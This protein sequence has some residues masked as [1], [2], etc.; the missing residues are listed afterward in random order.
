MKEYKVKRT[1]LSCL[2]SASSEYVSGEELSEILGFSRANTWKYIKK[3]INDGYQIEAVSKKGYKLISCPDKLYGYD[4]S[5]SLSSKLMGKNNIYYYET[6]TSTNDK[7]YQLAELGAEEGDIIVS[8]EQTG[9]KGRLGRKWISPPGVGLYFSVILR[10]ALP[11]TRLPALT[12]VSSYAVVKVLRE[13]YRL[14]AGIKWPND[15]YAQGKKIGGILTEIKAQQDMVDFVILGTGI[16]VNTP[17]SDL[18]VCAT[19]LY[20]CLDRMFIRKEVMSKIVET[21]EGTYYDYVDN[22]F[23]PILQKLKKY[24]T[25]L[26]KKI[27][28]E[29]YHKKIKGKAVDIDG[30]GALIVKTDD[31]TQRIF[32]GDIFFC[33][34][35]QNE[36]A[37]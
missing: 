29:T 35:D 10:P 9:G 37:D 7:A 28:I 15:I 8:E 23:D 2:Y 36:I 19:S 1:I 33:R 25:V 20:E 14:N 5:A 4:I 22:G 13:K 17:A 30:S 32:S 12:L 11:L 18:P 21:F 31:S 6:L 24:S 26:G 27:Y 16:N 3:I 34:E